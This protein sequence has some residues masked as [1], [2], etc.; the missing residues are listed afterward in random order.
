MDKKIRIAFSSEFVG[1][2]NRGVETYV[3]ELSKRLQKY[4]EVEII[5][6]KES[7]N[8]KKILAGNYDIVIPTNGR[9]QSLVAAVGKFFSRYKTIISGQA[10]IGRDDIWNIALTAPDVYVALTNYELEWAKKWAWRTKLVKIP[11]GVDLQKFSPKGPKAKVNLKG[12]IVLSVGALE[13]YKHH[14]RSIYAVSK[15]L[16]CSLLIIGKGEK[17]KDLEELGM[18]LLGKDRFLI[19]SVDF[20]KIAEYYRSADLFTL[21]SWD[22][23]AFGIVYVEA[24][25]CNLPVVAPDDPSRR[26]IVGDA[27]VLID[28]SNPNKYASALLQ[29]LEKDWKNI[30]RRKAENYSWD[31]IALQYKK[32]IEGL[33]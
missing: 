3:L 20:Q 19:I 17:E 14:E 26:E 11:N 2:V 30:P 22:R 25:A 4:F 31:K 7:Y 16:D 28:V 33:L 21:P 23:E 10:G 9:L 8:L 1:I 15:T 32:L 5:S 13:W 12:S 29:A 24:M 27:G 18:K 6:G